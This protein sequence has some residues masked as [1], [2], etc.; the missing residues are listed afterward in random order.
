VKRIVDEH[1]G[2]ISIENAAPRGAAVRI[3]LPLAA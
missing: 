1:Q 2:T 3:S